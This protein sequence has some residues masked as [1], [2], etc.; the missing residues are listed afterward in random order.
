[1]Q[2]SENEISDAM[3]DGMGG[4]CLNCE[5][6]VRE[7][8]PDARKYKCEFCGEMKVYGFEELLMMGEV[9]LTGC[10]GE[11]GAE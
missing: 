1:M 7:V 2:V 3:A 9:E 4:A 11:G 10:D 6:R 5:E 8:E